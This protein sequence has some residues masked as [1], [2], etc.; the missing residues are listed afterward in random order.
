MACNFP[1]RGY[2]S[3]DGSPLSFGVGGVR[4]P[5]GRDLEVPCGRCMQC[6][7]DRGRQH[8]ARC[9]HEAQ[10]HERNSFVTLTYS[11]EFLPPAGNLLYRDFQLFLKRLR[12]KCPVRFFMCGEYG[13]IKGRPHY[14]AI[15][16]GVDWEDR[17]PW[18]KG[19]S[20]EMT[21]TSAELDS[22]WQLGQTFVGDATFASA[23]YVARYLLKKE[24]GPDS[25]QRRQIVDVTTGEIVERV[26]EFCH[27]SLRPGIGAGWLDKFW[28]DVY[29]Q[30]QVVLAGGKEMKAPRFYDKRFEEREPVAFERLKAE[31]QALALLRWDDSSPRRLR[32]KDQVL[33]ARVAFLK[34]SDQ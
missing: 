34:R 6:R 15:L 14:H 29:P 4:P 7:L 32:D 13:D 10:M 1:V 2:Q 26:H 5:G 3:K 20:G 22:Y 21:Y 23:A 27:M 8:A 33:R 19:E 16:F 9:V 17:K 31:R 12:K 28:S 30:G 18:R 25:G 24:L 11:D